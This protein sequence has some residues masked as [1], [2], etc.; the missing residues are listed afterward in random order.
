MH[1]S[2]LL[3]TLL[4]CGLDPSLASPADAVPGQVPAAV[5][6]LSEPVDARRLRGDFEAPARVLLVS[7]AD[8]PRATER[9]AEQVL[10]SGSAL[11]LIRESGSSAPAFARLL[12]TLEQRPGADVEGHP[13]IVDTPWVRDWGPL[14]LD[15]SEGHRSLWL[16]ADHHA[17]AREHDDAAAAWLAGHHGVELAT[18]GWALDGGAFIS[19]GAGLCVLS[20]EYLELRGIARAEAALGQLLAGL[21]CRATALVPTLLD[22]HTKHVD[23]IAQ[24][25]GP[26]R[27]M[28]AEIDDALAGQSEDARRLA[29]AEL[30][31]R[32]AA[33]A[34]GRSLEVIHVPTP[35]SEPGQNPRT[36][37]NGLRLRDR[38]LMPTY[39]ALGEAWERRA[40]AAVREA[41]GEVPVVA[42]DATEMIAAGGALHC[43]ALGLFM[44]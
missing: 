30:G 42:I 44:P 8:W 12:A 37:V 32:Q 34:L 2:S 24:F 5:V 10:D 4:G 18:F 16:D 33:C 35:P 11:A 40:L 9:V 20:F 27:L 7:T 36:H 1:V 25:V 39:P 23:M 28:I 22:E 13:G 19:D 41:V 21:G 3:T 31:I 38:Y 26:T 6:I 17:D 43:A 29:A 14:Q 15:A